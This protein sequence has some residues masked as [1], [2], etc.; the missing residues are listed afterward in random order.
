M[1]DIGLANVAS[2]QK[3]LKSSDGLQTYTGRKGSGADYPLTPG[4]AYFVKM[5]TTVNYTPSHY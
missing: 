5:N 4:E 1:D 3:F 2:V